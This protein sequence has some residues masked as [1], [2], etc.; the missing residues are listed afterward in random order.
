MKARG[1]VEDSGLGATANV[2]ITIIYLF[3]AFGAAIFHCFQV[4]EI[5]HANLAR[6]LANESP[7]PF[8]YRVLIP[9]LLQALISSGVQFQ[10]AML[11]VSWLGFFGAFLA[12]RW[13]AR[14]FV[15]DALAATAPF[16]VVTCIVGNIHLYF[17]WDPYTLMF[18]P[19]LFGLIYLRRWAVFLAVFALATLSKEST[20]IAIFAALLFSFST[21]DT[22]ARKPA[23]LTALAASIL[24]VAIKLLL[25]ATMGKD[26]SQ[27]FE[28]Q[29]KSNLDFLLGRNVP[30]D[31][32]NVLAA[33]AYFKQNLDVAKNALHPF[34]SYPA[35]LVS[36]FLR[37]GH[38]LWLTLFIK[39]S[40]KAAYLKAL[41]W[42]VP[43]Y[44][45]TLL[46][47]GIITEKRIYFELYPILVAHALVV[48]NLS[49]PHGKAEQPSG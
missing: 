28:W 48:L 45:V 6:L 7:P 41:T 5:W 4:P 22:K 27:S 32:L 19:L 9:W 25:L 15:P 14:L 23:L 37:W 43:M 13:W 39:N 40:E 33:G 42:L 31:E 20:F 1:S 44:F 34:Y 10:V 16:I 47:V 46:F 24:W 29:L 35:V 36:S 38:F 3:A 12:M 30:L 49:M 21:P 18:I 11:L 2:L 8:C 17:P 26:I